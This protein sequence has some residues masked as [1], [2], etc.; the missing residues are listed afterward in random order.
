LVGRY[1][2][3]P[4]VNFHPILNEVYNNI[5]SIHTDLHGLLHERRKK[6][7]QWKTI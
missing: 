4:T 3:H 5:A 1:H 2:F 7:T 6:I